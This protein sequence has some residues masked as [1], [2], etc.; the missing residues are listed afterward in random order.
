MILY[1]QT[2]RS[3]PYQCWVQAVLKGFSQTLRMQHALQLRCPQRVSISSLRIRA[4]VQGHG[5]GS[6]KGKET[7][8]A[9][10]VI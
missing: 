9:F 8:I 6:H 2:D 5:L 3:Y 1:L 4:S 7:S 10:W